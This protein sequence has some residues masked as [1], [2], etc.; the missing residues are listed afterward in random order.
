MKI[1]LIG[2]LALVL[3][4]ACRSAQDGTCSGD[5][6]CKEAVCVFGKCQECASNSDCKETK[7]CEKNQCIVAPAPV[8]K[9]EQTAPESTTASSC[10][11][12][13]TVHFDFDKYEIKAA[14]RDL[15]TELAACLRTNLSAKIILAGNTD[16]R[17]TV[18]YNLAL[19][20]RRAKAA[21]DY[22][23]N[24]GIDASRMSTISY[25]KEKPVDPEH[26]EEAWA[27]NRRT[28]ITVD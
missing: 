25:G 15:L 16:E 17:G 10:L 9:M 27:R 7:V 8:T 5:S 3:L 26:N 18:E 6:D 22:L 24:S 13:A 20:E 23:Q 14:D 19:G 1:R 28:D 4:S 2:I 12:T 21:Y 11:E